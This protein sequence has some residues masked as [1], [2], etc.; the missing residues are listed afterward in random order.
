LHSHTVKQPPWLGVH[1]EEVAN[2]CSTQGA[3]ELYATGPG[4]Y[5]YTVKDEPDFWLICLVSA[6]LLSCSMNVLRA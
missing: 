3:E 2:G 1:A 6:A 4:N 5:T